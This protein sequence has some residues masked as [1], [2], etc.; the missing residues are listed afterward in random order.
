MERNHASVPPVR[1]QQRS[2]SQYN[3]QQ[4]NRHRRS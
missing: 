1:F 4:L 3:L 2:F